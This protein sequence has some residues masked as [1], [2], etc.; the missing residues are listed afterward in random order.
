MVLT[1]VCTVSMEEQL[2]INVINN[3]FRFSLTGR[4]L[5]YEMIHL[6]KTIIIVTEVK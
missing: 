3:L 2:P 5:D 1:N 6:S 4:L